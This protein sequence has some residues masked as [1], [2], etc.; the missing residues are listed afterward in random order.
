M[1][2]NGQTTV[3]STM[4]PLSYTKGI[5]PTQG[6]WPGYQP[7]LGQLDEGFSLEFSPLMTTDSRTT[8]AVVKL[9]LCPV[10]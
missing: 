7:E 10:E 6:V 8:D 2:L 9:K 1:V 4:R 3:I 5:I